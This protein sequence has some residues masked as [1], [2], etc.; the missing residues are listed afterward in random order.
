MLD[1]CQDYQLMYY[2]A[3]HCIGIG[4]KRNGKQILQFG[5]RDFSAFSRDQLW[6]VGKEVSALIV[7]GKSL[8]E[9]KAFAN[10]KL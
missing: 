8:E 9:A 6:E 5:G 7:D 4:D 2:K 1:P 10:T 3:Q